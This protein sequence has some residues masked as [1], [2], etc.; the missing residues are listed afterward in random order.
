MVV[1]CVK[2]SVTDNNPYIL[3]GNSQEWMKVGDEYVV[4]GVRVSSESNYFMIFNGD[5]LVEVPLQKFE[6]IEG[7]VS[8]LW[9][10]QSDELNG[11]TFWPKLFYEDNFFE[12]FSEWEEKERKAFEVLSKSFVAY[13]KALQ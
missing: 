12:N 1:Q 5:H 13:K 7:T 2:A 3:N 6:I 4:Y 8:P 11:I 9:V 10:V